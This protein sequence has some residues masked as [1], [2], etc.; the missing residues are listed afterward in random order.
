MTTPISISHE[1]GDSSRANSQTP[2]LD[3]LN[4][5]VTKYLEE[6]KKLYEEAWRG[7]SSYIYRVV[8][9]LKENNGSL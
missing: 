6:G 2:T 9:R 4:E 5:R 7:N 3:Q 1:E 8:L